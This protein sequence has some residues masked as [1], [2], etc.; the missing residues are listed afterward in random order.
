MEVG[1]GART[2]TKPVARKLVLVLRHPMGISTLNRAM[3]PVELAGVAEA[4]AGSE[5]QRRDAAAIDD[6]ALA[7]E[8][9]PE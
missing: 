5:I 9:W 6:A 7:T 2:P 4:L 3:S 8:R 1:G